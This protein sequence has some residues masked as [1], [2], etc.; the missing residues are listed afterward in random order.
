MG[1]SFMEVKL[2]DL[3]INILRLVQVN[4]KLSTSE[5]SR[6]LRKPR[7]TIASRLTK[8]QRLGMITGYRALLDSE[9][10]GFQLV[11]FVFIT[12][13]RGLKEISSQVEL[14]KKILDICKKNP[15]LWIEEIHIVT[16]RYDLA[17]KAHI[18]R[19]EYLTDLLI[20]LL[21]KLRE[22]EHTETFLVLQTID[23]FRPAPL[24]TST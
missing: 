2:D 15:N 17:L 10:I 21:P 7:T 23:E 24:A 22:V 8:L 1:N 14:A 19:L 11:V 5:I 6:I 4:C 13:R 12:V 16:G 9:K 3:D 20:N 18:K